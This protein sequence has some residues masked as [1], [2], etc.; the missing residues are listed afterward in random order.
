MSKSFLIEDFEPATFALFR[1]GEFDARVE[2]G[3]EELRD[4][5]ACPRNCHIDRLKDERR[6]CNVGRYA[7]VSSAF[8]HF[9]EEDCLRGW[10]GSGTIFFGL[11]NL[12]CVFCQNWD[13]SQQHAGKECTGEEIA[14]LALALQARG[15]P[16]IISAPPRDA[17]PGRRGGGDLRLAR[18]RG[19][20]R[21]LC[22]HHG[23][24]PAR[25]PRGHD[26]KIR[27]HQPPTAAVG[28]ASR[29]RGRAR[30]GFGSGDT[31]FISSDNGRVTIFK[32]F[33]LSMVS[34]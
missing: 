18:E 22:Q 9:G 1:R 12:R 32:S 20:A 27:R 33:E 23:P 13:I 10:K 26:A 21:Y 31:I 11:C 6:V 7:I 2:A 5:C 14:D 15:C 16:R 29:I 30:C 3:L 24:V 4:C 8:P 19:F 34:P 25:A 17:G 28:E